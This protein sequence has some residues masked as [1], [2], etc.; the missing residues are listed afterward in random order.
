MPTTTNITTTYAGEHAGKFISA[1][2]LTANTI[3][4]GAIEVK[5]NVKYK[6]VIS[7]IETDGLLKDGSCDFD[8]TSTITKTERILE[9]KSLQVN[10]QICKTSLRNDWQA[11]EMGFSAHD[12]IPKSF[13]DYLIGYVSD[14]T[15]SAVETALWSG[16][17]AGN[18]SFD[19]F[20]TLLSLDADLPTAQEVTGIAVTS[21]N[22]VAEMG[23][24]LDAI[25]TSLFGADDLLL[26]ISQDVYRKYVRA[27]GTSG[28]IDRFNNQRIDELVF[29]GVKI[30]VAN[31]MS[32]NTMICTRKSNL[33]FGTGLLSDHNEVSIIDMA[34]LDGSQN[35]RYVARFTAG[36]QYGA[37]EDI[38]T[39][40]IVNAANPV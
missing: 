16:T 26:Y 24:V 19:G 17:Q 34:M 8:P 1:S 4:G 25:P 7:R 39:Y 27:L 32:A 2:L 18:G 14:K 37:V 11:V 35:V 29:D 36:V 28:H 23:K 22:V 40:G 15:A 33:Y 13:Q 12:E 38:V 10:L 30:F 6:E 9:P 3:M 20:E 5:P 21:A 31:G